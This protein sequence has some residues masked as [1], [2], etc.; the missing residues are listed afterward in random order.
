VPFYLKKKSYETKQVLCLLAINEYK[1]KPGTRGD[2][3]KSH[4]HRL[5]V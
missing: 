5:A 4:F 1:I 2:K 3:I